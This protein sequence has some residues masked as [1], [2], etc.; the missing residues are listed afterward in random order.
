M[1]LLKKWQGDFSNDEMC[2]LWVFFTKVFCCFSVQVQYTVL[3][4]NT[5]LQECV[6]MGPGYHFK[7][8]S[9]KINLTPQDPDP[10]ARVQVESN[11]SAVSTVKIPYCNQARA[12]R[13]C[14]YNIFIAPIFK[15]TTNYNV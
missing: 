11:I 3:A 4:I 14:S 10:L 7:E 8:S 5:N 1:K 13:S 9:Q 2:D 6:D 12:P 15:W